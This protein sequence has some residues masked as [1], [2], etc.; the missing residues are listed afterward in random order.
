MTAV[1]KSN[2]SGASVVW[3]A[4]EMNFGQTLNISDT[5]GVGFF[6]LI[7]TTRR[8]GGYPPITCFMMK[9]GGTYTVTLERNTAG[10]LVVKVT[11]GP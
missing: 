1:D 10:L 9:P 4:Q 7:P 6:L 2:G 8:P 5:N 11:S 3:N